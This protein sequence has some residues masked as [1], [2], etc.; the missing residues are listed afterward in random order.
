MGTSGS[1]CRRPAATFW[2]GP[3]AMSRR[4]STSRRFP[5]SDSEW[6]MSFI[7]KPVPTFPGHALVRAGDA[8]L[9]HDLAPAGD[10]GADERRQLPRRRTVEGH[11]ADPADLLLD[12]GQGHDGFELV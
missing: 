11:H 1:R 2:H 8:G 9:L 6:R 5:S 10:L 7:G 3:F 12:V 4:I